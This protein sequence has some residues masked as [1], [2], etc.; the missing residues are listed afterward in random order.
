[1][2]AKR[3]CEACFD[4][5]A[6][7][8]SNILSQPVGSLP[9]HR[10]GGV[11]VV[12]T[13]LFAVV[14]LGV[15]VDVVTASGQS[16]GDWVYNIQDTELRRGLWCVVPS[17]YSLNFD[18]EVAVEVDPDTLPKVEPESD[19]KLEKAEVD[20]RLDICIERY[21][22]EY[23]PKYGPEELIETMTRLARRRKGWG[24]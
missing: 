24:P 13:E 3:D 14:L 5:Q 16:W 17:S 11:S 4:G 21:M 15:I 12:N 22:D 1:M 19:D 6:H 18:D 9:A 2:D 23:N 10:G 7:D 8:L 20:V